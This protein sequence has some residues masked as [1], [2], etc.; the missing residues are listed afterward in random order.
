MKGRL[1]ALAMLLAAAQASADVGK[2][3]EA[4]HASTS[5]SARRHRLSEPIRVYATNDSHTELCYVSGNAIY[6]YRLVD[7]VVVRP[8]Y[9]KMFNVAAVNRITYQAGPGGGSFQI[10]VDGT[11]EISFGG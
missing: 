5:E 1:L 7:D 9:P 8:D 2:L 11:L 4:F 10:W 3:F 6:L